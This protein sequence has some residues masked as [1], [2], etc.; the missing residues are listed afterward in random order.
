MAGLYVQDVFK[1]RNRQ[2]A[3]ER[4]YTVGLG[5]AG[6]GVDLALEERLVQLSE[7]HMVEQSVVGAVR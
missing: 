7:A 1:A 5:L 2:E 3:E 4:I 6:V